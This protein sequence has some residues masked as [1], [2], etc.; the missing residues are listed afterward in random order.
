MCK[1]LTNEAARGNGRYDLRPRDPNCVYINPRIQDEPAQYGIAELAKE[2]GKEKRLWM[3]IDLHVHCNKDSAFV[4]GTFGE[5]KEQS[6]NSF[7][8]IRALDCYSKHFDY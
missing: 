8:F 1:I 3:Y 2:F 5:G 4:F 7:S 6:L